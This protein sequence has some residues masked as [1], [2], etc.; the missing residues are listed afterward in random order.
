MS[1]AT[2]AL[3]ANQ[4][5]KP[6][7]FTNAEGKSYQMC[8]VTPKAKTTLNAAGF[9]SKHGEWDKLSISAFSNQLSLIKLNMNPDLKNQ[10]GETKLYEMV[11]SDQENA[12]GK[13]K[14]AAFKE[15]GKLAQL[16]ITMPDDDKNLDDMKIKVFLSRKAVDGTFEKKEIEMSAKEVSVILFE[17]NKEVIYALKDFQAKNMGKDINAVENELDKEG[18][19]FEEIKNQR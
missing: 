16:S 15:G 4:V 11:W 12:N 8:F 19:I 13:N 17:N 5:S 2:S 14:P 3:F 18:E 7:T 6:K 1:Y 10:K 9:V